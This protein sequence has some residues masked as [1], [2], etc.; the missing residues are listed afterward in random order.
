MMGDATTQPASLQSLSVELQRFIIRLLDPIGL[1][2]LSQAS[3]YFRRTINPTRAEQIERFL[4]LECL[5]EYGGDR[6]AIL[7]LDRDQIVAGPD[8]NTDSWQ[9][10]RWACAFCLRLLSHTHFDNHFLLRRRYRKPSPRS[11]AA[12]ALTAWEPSLVGRRAGQ[13]ARRQQLRQA[14]VAGAGEEDGHGRTVLPEQLGCARL[15]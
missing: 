11:P 3:R 7:P 2:S 9:Q 15:R 14:A 6:P 10:S 13:K 8:W 4:A 5:P 12:T 1:F